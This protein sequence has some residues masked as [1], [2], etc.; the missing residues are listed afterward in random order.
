MVNAAT[1]AA[2]I[3]SSFGG[4]RFILLIEVCAGVL[5]TPG[6][7]DI[8]LGDVIVSTGVF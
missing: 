1:V 2:G 4:V 6:G 7:I 3:R 8:L 5:K